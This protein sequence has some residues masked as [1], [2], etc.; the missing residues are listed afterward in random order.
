MKVLHNQKSREEL[1]R[2]LKAEDF[3]R[4]AASFYRYFHIEDPQT[5]RD[6]LYRAWFSLKVFGRVYVSRE[7]IN[8]QL[9]VPNH[10]W[11]S[12]EASLKRFKDLENVFLNHSLTSGEK[13]FIKLDVRVRERVVADGLE[14]LIFETSSP[15]RSLDPIAFH[16]ALQEKDVVPVDVRNFYECETGRFDKAICP[17]SEFFSDV[18]PELKERLTLYRNRKLLLYCTG[19]IRCE[20]AGAYLKHEGYENVFQLRGGIINYLRETRKAKIASYFQG[21]LFVFDG[22]MAEQTV[23]KTIS[24]CHQC[25]KPYDIHSDCAFVECNRLM[26]Q[27]S[28]CAEMYNGCCSV[29]CQEI[30]KEKTDG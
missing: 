27:C 2:L 29:E 11:T 22:R 3:P 17:T 19:G 15:G 13:A 30:L 20:K 5:F 12:F 9:S 28:N 8:A 26:I 24:H 4:K 6:D 16:K 10:E 21:N 7:G 14:D 23:G 18:L 25:Q 1:L